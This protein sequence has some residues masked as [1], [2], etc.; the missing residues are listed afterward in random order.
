MILALLLH[1]SLLATNLGV[2][3]SGGSGGTLVDE[4]F[5]DVRDNTT[6]GNSSFDK[7]VKLFITTNGKK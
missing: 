1:L 3:H 5:V 4:R 7:G 2:R 6:T